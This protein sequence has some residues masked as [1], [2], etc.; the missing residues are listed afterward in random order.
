MATAETTWRE[1]IGAA[2]SSFSAPEGGGRPL[3]FHC[4]KSKRTCAEAASACCSCCCS[5]FLSS[6][7]WCSSELEA[8]AGAPKMGEFSRR[9]GLSAP[10]RET[11]GTE[12]FSQ[13]VK[14]TKKHLTAQ[15]AQSLEGLTVTSV[16]SVWTGGGSSCWFDHTGIIYPTSQSAAGGG[17]G[18]VVHRFAV[19][20]E[21]GNR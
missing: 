3:C 19:T 10:C 1:T 7:I 8:S 11:E 4:V 6:W 15:K 13:M 17:G 20:S 21:T 14:K 16:T 5:C 9:G 18:G 2:F 12:D